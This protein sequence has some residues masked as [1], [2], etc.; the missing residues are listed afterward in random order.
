MHFI[1]LCLFFLCWVYKFYS[2]E[3][4]DIAVLTLNKRATH[5]GWQQERKWESILS[6]IYSAMKIDQQNMSVIAFMFIAIIPSTV[7][8]S[9]RPIYIFLAFNFKTDIAVICGSFCI[10]IDFTFDILTSN[11]VLFVV[12]NVQIDV[13]ILLE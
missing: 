9:F 7:A 1:N 3:V 10:E 6:L 12:V 13:F 8:T 2:K 4:F 5:H 11:I